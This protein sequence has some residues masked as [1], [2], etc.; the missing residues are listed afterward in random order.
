[1]WAANGRAYSRSDSLLSLGNYV[2]PRPAA[3]SNQF[4][5]EAQ[6]EQPFEENQPRSTYEA[7]AI[8][9]YRNAAKLTPTL[10]LASK[11]AEFA[12]R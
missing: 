1:V 10:T 11:T 4:T 3:G 8:V 6:L 12:H 7:P 5:T 2:A 9:D